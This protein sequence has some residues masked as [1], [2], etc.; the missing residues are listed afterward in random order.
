MNMIPERLFPVEGT[1]GAVTTNGGITADY[2]SVKNAAWVD[3]VVHL[4]QVV[5]HATAFTPYRATAA[6]PTGNVV[7][8][9][10]VQIWYGNVTTSSNALTKQTDATSF[11]IGVGVT[12]DAIIVFSIDPATLGDTYDVLGIT[13]AD[14]SQATN[15]CS[16][17]YY[18]Q[19]KYPQRAASNTDYL[20][21]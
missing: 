13:V 15:L 2:I 4:K 5:E 10:A 17:M 6:A 12:G 7:L 1:T 8:A 11:T 20:T 14:S 3:I 16:I 21:D 18:I 9:N 19:P